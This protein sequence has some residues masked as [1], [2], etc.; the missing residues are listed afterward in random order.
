M[1]CTAAYTWVTVKL[2]GLFRLNACDGVDGLLNRLH[3][4]DF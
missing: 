2:D 4:D 1:G 3:G